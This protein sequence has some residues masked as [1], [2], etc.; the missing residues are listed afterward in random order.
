MEKTDFYLHCLWIVY[1]DLMCI[2]EV[3]SDM[4]H[5]YE[6]TGDLSARKNV[7]VFQLLTR[8]ITGKVKDIIDEMENSKTDED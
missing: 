5:Y 1:D 6:S 7:T 2:R 3:L 8:S 4:E